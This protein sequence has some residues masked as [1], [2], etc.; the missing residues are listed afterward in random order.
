LIGALAGLRVVKFLDG[1]VKPEYELGYDKGALGIEVTVEGEKEPYQLI[2]GKE[3][4]E[5]YVAQSK[6]LGDQLFLVGK[7]PFKEFR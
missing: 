4:S 3:E 5:G 1:A 6:Q 7:M 2:L